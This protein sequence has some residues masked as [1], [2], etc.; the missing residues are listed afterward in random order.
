MSIKLRYTGQYFSKTEDRYLQAIKSAAK[1]AFEN[2]MHH[3]ETMKRI[4]KAYLTNRVCS[5][6]GSMYHILPELKQ[7]RI[8]WLT[9]SKLPNNSLNIF[10]KPNI[11][12]YIENKSSKT[13]EHQPDELDNNL[14]ENNHEEC[15]YPPQKN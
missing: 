3:H 1:E 10:R 13:C 15:S 6:Q 14:I 2:N 7:R 11:D 12:C 4:V 9:L 8:F 5:V